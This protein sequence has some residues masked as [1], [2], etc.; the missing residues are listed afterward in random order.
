MSYDNYQETINLPALTGGFERVS[1]GAP[2]RSVMPQDAQDGTPLAYG[3]HEAFARLS[4]RYSA[5][6]SYR[7][8]L[9]T[10]L[11]AATPGALYEAASQLSQ[12]PE[13]KRRVSELRALA[14][15]ESALD[16]A[17][18]ARE[19]HEMAHA[20]L[21]E[22]IYRGACRH[23]H[24]AGHQYQWIDEA[25]FLAAWANAVE[26]DTTPP[27]EAGGHGYNG[28]QRP[29]EDCP[30]CF[31][32]GDHW[33]TADISKASTPVRRLVKG[34]GKRGELLL[35]DPM[36]VRDQLH[37]LLGAY[38]ERSENVNLNATVGAPRNVSAA[39]VLDAF[40]KSRRPNT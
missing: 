17:E 16:A 22:V 10:K 37:R 25:E 28:A 1:Q 2:G 5:A 31:G 30:R 19:L 20:D 18:L 13:V 39:D 35:V 9:G 34:V 11:K 15:R 40:H 36:T 14:A 33:F 8:A 7:R 27:S 32:G 4:L 3:P 21:S 26:A 6:E 12:R 29:T 38:I 23:C 24:G